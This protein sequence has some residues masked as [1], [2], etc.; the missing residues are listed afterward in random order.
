MI[1]HSS[2][3]VLAAITKSHS[4]FFFLITKCYE[5]QPCLVSFQMYLIFQCRDTN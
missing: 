2:Q 5:K 3:V 1:N 4:Y